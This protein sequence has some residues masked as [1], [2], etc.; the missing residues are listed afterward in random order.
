MKRTRLLALTLVV[1]MML[2]GAGYA[3]WSEALAINATVDTGELAFAF[4]DAGFVGGQYVSGSAEVDTEDDNI[5]NLE[6]INMHPGS[7]ATVEFCM[8]NTGTI[9]LKFDDFEFTGDD[10][11]DQLLVKELP[12]GAYMPVEDYFKGLIE[13]TELDVVEGVG[14]KVCKDLEFYVKKCATE[15]DFAELANYAFGI[16]ARVEQYNDDGSCEEEEEPEEPVDPDPIAV[17][18]VTIVKDS[19]GCYKVYNVGGIDPAGATVNYQWQMRTAKW[20]GGWNAWQNV[21]SN[22]DEYSNSNWG[23]IQVRLIVTGTG[24]YTGSATSNII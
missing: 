12:D 2:M 18:S 16:K 20:H 10:D 14:E 5:L 9:G 15:E 23:T 24:D 3:F 19:N 17:Q 4:S 13:G 7:T 21:G 8:N 11:L 22:Q 1:A 6:F